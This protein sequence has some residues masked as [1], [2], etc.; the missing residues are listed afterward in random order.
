VSKPCFIFVF[1][2]GA[3][4]QLGL[5]GGMLHRRAGV[6]GDVTVLVRGR[7]QVQ[8]FPV[9]LQSHASAVERSDGCRNHRYF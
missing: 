7:I 8:D 1:R 6:G 9:Y 3:L 4:L 2:C 5:G